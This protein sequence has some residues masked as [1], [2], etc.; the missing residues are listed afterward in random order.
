MQKPKG[1]KARNEDAKDEGERRKRTTT[2]ANDA[3]EAR[4]NDTATTRPT[5]HSHT[6]HGERKVFFTWIQNRSTVSTL[7]PQRKEQERASGRAQG[8]H[9]HTHV[10]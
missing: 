3:N 6:T 8:A 10:Q 4:G 7:E 1:E 5:T 2:K 9:T